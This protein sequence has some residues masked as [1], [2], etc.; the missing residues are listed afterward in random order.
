MKAGG[1]V[2]SAL[3][4]SASKQADISRISK[5]ANDHEYGGGIDDL[6]DE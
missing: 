3:D 6:E 4:V 1:G 2:K 5:K